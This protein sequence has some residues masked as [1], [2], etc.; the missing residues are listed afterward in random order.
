[1][2][3]GAEQL[4]ELY[5]ELLNSFDD[6]GPDLNL[7]SPLPSDDPYKKTTRK[8]TGDSDKLLDLYQ[9]YADETSPDQHSS[10][11]VHPH[12]SS[13]PSSPTPLSMIIL[14]PWTF[15]VLRRITHRHPGFVDI[16]EWIVVAWGLVHC[17]PPSAID[18][19]TYNTWILSIVS[20]ITNAPFNIP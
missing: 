16:N 20:S 4:D 1:M 3:K 18:D 8:E 15:A 12:N 6:D 5:N 2:P 11:A 13:V 14:L 19:F 10:R 17:E 9:S 7:T